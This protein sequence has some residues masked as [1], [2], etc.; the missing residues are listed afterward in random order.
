[1]NSATCDPMDRLRG[2][3]VCDVMQRSVVSIPQS[4]TAC[5]AAARLVAA[6]TSGA[7]VVDEA[8]RCVGMLSSRDYLSETAR[9]CRLQGA[10]GS[11]WAAE[12]FTPVRKMMSTAVQSIDAGAS[13]MH[14]ARVMCLEHIH[15]VVAL[16]ERGAPAGVLTT[17]DIVAAV[18]AAADEERQELSRDA[19]GRQA[20]RIR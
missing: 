8:G 17:L 9:A 11:A 10:P 15:R 5:E 14:A 1:M 4:D 13:L 18:L 20:K 7:P 2:L 6:G 19:T 3:R 16:D 12:D